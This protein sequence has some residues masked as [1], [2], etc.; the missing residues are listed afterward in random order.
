MIRRT[1]EVKIAMVATIHKAM[2]YLNHPAMQNV[3][4]YVPATEIA[5]FLQTDVQLLGYP[6]RLQEKKYVMGDLQLAADYLS[7]P[8]ITALPFEI[9]TPNIAQSL[10]QLIADLK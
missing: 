5:R 10:R 2:E 4:G 7:H 8:T 3:R 1:P 9:R 6:G